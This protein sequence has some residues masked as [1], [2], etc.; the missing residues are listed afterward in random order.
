MN[1]FTDKQEVR[2]A[3]QPHAPSRPPL[4][5]EAIESIAS[6]LQVIAE[7]TRIRLMECLGG[8]EARVQGLASQLGTTRQNVSQHLGILRHAGIV[9]RRRAG[10][11]VLYELADFSGWWMVEQAAAALSEQE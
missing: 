9:N 6:W 7:P 8:G 5:D 4:A 11:S 1:D 2:S 3:G 10:N